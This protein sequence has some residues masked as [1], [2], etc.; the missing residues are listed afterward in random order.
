MKDGSFSQNAFKVD[1]AITLINKIIVPSWDFGNYFDCTSRVA[2]QEKEYLFHS[3]SRLFC[4]EFPNAFYF[5][6]PAQDST[7]HGKKV[8]FSSWLHE[9]LF[10]RKTIGSIALPNCAILD[11]DSANDN[12]K[13]MARLPRY[14][15]PVNPSMSYSAATTAVLFFREKM[16]I[17]F[18]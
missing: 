15:V 5:Y 3:M 12:D 10:F 9:Y 1:S 8:N 7:Q 11:P 17:S 2:N 13:S 16:I 14:D 4:L 18:I 6:Q